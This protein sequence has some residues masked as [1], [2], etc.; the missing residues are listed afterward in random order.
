MGE[1]WIEEKAFL[2][3]VG[4]T[5]Q[6]EEFIFKVLE[7]R[8]V[9]CKNRTVLGSIQKNPTNICTIDKCLIFVIFHI[10]T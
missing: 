4:H 7:R 1:I 10:K 8:K 6:F 5:F 3:V 2:F 9:N